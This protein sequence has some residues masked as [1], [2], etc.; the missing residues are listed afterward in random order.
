MVDYILV[1]KGLLAALSGYSDS[2]W[3]GDYNT[4]KS[5][6]GYVFNIRSAVISWS[7]KL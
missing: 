4:W 7:L 2:D 5:T 6:L 3:A 1:F